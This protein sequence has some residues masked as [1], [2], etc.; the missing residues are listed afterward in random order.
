MA[1]FMTTTITKIQAIEDN[2]GGLHLAVFKGDEVAH[3]FSDFQ[4]AGLRG[5]S[6]QEEVAGAVEHGVGKWDGDA[7]SPAA[8]YAEMTSY[9]YGWKIV[10][11]WDEG[12]GLTLYP[13]DMGA[14]ARIWARIPHDDE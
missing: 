10:G 4:F 11:E 3:L 6:L 5:P 14:A 1:A 13:Q 7:E 9:A 8:E 2:G 12:N